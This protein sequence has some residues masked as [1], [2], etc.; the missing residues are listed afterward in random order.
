[1]L[2]KRWKT[3][4]SLGI[5]QILAEQ[6]Q[7]GGNILCSVIHKLI[8]SIWNKKEFPQQWKD[9]TTVPIYKQ[10]DKTEFSNYRKI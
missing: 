6:I 4:E 9:S 3:Y 8:N 5:D 2:L 7:V 1:L 10:G